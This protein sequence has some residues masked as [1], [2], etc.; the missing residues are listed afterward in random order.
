M[1]DR[2]TLPKD[3]KEQ[4]MA[5]FGKLMTE[6]KKNESK[7]ET[8]EEEAEK[9]KSKQLLEIASSYTVNNIVN[10]MASLQL[11]FSGTIDAISED[12]DRESSKLDEL[13]RAI[14]IKTKQLEELRQV[15]LVADVLYILRLEHQERLRILQNHTAAIKEAIEKEMTQTRKV[16][17]RERQE[18]ALKV[19]EEAELSTKI[20]EREAADYLYEIERLYKIEMDE[21]EKVKRQQERELHESDRQKNKAW[22][23][24]ERFLANSRAEFEANQQK[25]AGF[26]A[27]IQEESNK[28]RQE[29]IRETD[30]E[31]KVKADLFEKE[32]EATKQG[33]EFKVQ[34]LEAIIN[35]YVEQIA[36]VSTQLQAATDRTQSLAMKAFQNNKSDS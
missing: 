15:R 10:C 21:Y 23:E 36:G 7:V 1:T 26:D 12:L 25:I 17:E 34:S 32:W 9:E 30:R 22:A 4:I 8:K 24:R 14:F 16:W 11:E 28:A 20:R 13:E 18:F 33:Y 3:A 29:A 27:K 2:Q 35:K 31:A 6:Y 19:T 5:A